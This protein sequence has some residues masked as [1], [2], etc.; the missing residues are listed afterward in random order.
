L[1]AEP[2]NGFRLSR[3]GV[4]RAADLR[5]PKSVR[6]GQRDF[7]DHVASVPGNYRGT[8]DFVRVFPDVNFDET[9][10]FP[11]QDRAIHVAEM[12]HIG[13]DLD[14]L[15]VCVVAAE[16][17]MGKFR[18]RLRTPRN[19]EGTRFLQAPE[20]SVLNHD[21]GHEVGGVSKLIRRTDVASR[22]DQRVGRLHPIIDIG[23]QLKIEFVTWFELLKMCHQR[24]SF[25]R[26]VITLRTTSGNNPSIT[27]APGIWQSKGSRHSESDGYYSIHRLNT[28]DR[29]VKQSTSRGQ[30]PLDVKLEYIRCGPVQWPGI[31]GRKP[32][33][34]VRVGWWRHGLSSDCIAKGSGTMKQATRTRQPTAEERERWQAAAE[35]TN[36]E[37]ER[38]FWNPIVAQLQG[39]ADMDSAV[40][41]LKGVRESQG[42]TLRTLEETA[43]IPRGNLSRL[44]NHKNT[45]DFSTLQKYA[46]ALGKVVRVVVVDE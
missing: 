19:C 27:K 41:L 31:A 33:R 5:Q 38:E 16:P 23:L 21:A 2:T 34:G 3:I 40:D 37:R 17:N 36:V 25:E 28:N 35:A 15:L 46:A 39:Q 13:V 44:E 6:H 30:P 10:F 29:Q 1:V 22:V 7:W 11:F 45:P 26:R 14:A 43:G 12:L 24:F 32:R 9:L 4:N 42:I 20:E 8:H 18:R